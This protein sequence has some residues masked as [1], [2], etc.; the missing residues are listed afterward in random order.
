MT[1]A[2]KLIY[3]YLSRMGVFCCFAFGFIVITVFFVPGLPVLPLLY[4]VPFTVFFLIREANLVKSVYLPLQFLSLI[5]FAGIILLVFGNPDSRIPLI[6]TLSCLAFLFIYSARTETCE[7]ADSSFL[8]SLFLNGLAGCALFVGRS[9]ASK[10]IYP[11]ALVILIITAVSRFLCKFYSGF[12]FLTRMRSWRQQS[13][14]S[15]KRVSRRG[16]C[17]AY[18][19]VFAGLGLMLILLIPEYDNRINFALPESSRTRA[20]ELGLFLSQTELEMPVNELYEDEFKIYDFNEW[21]DTEPYSYRNLVTAAGVIA[22]VLIAAVIVAS[23]FSYKKI[24]NDKDEFGDF[25]DADEEGVYTE[26]RKSRRQRRVAFNT[27]RLVRTMFKKKVNAHR[28]R[29]LAVKPADTA[30]RLSE[31]IGE[32]EDIT[33]LSAL[34]H[35]A[36]YSDDPVSGADAARVRKKR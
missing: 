32:T 31:G 28:K 11:V 7:F 30:K 13:K 12:N 1:D 9:Q 17:F 22:V 26:S 2:Q 35:L 4:L 18:I 5:V 36:R 16:Q 14:D 19:F 8:L 34:Y 6:L 24:R 20:E 33:E 10:D 15:A 27:N 23:L 21:E 3:A 25:S 29:G